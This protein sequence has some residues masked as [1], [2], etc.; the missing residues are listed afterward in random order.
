[1]Q[2][3][4]YIYLITYL[5]IYLLNV[6]NCF[7]RKLSPIKLSPNLVIFKRILTINELNDK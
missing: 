7:R 5:Y 2:L 6:C 1:M 4:I 3:F